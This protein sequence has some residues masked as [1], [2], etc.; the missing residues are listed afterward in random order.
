MISP[1]E[2]LLRIIFGKKRESEHHRCKD[3]DDFI[4]MTELTCL[5]KK[6][7]IEPGPRRLIRPSP[8]KLDFK[9]DFDRMVHTFATNFLVVLKGHMS[10]MSPYPPR[11]RTLMAS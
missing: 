7:L 2:K 3:S 4:N 1:G 5:T 9:P 8:S 11:T 6:Y 10:Y